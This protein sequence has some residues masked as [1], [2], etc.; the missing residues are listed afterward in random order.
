VARGLSKGMAVAHGREREPGR[1]FEAT[2][3]ECQFIGGGTAAPASSDMGQRN[4]GRAMAQVRSRALSQ[5]GSIRPEAWTRVR[6]NASDAASR[7]QPAAWSRRE[8]AGLV[9]TPSSDGSALDGEPGRGKRK[10]LRPNRDSPRVIDSGEDP[11][12]CRRA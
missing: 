6:P 9:G 12:A 7:W 10:I 3:G 1:R 11:V 8:S 5:A 2:G 4:A